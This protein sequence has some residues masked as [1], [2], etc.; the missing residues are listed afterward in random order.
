MQQHLSNISGEVQKLLVLLTACV[1]SSHATSSAVSELQREAALLQSTSQEA[2][3]HLEYMSDTLK[4]MADDTTTA[5]DVDVA[6]RQLNSTM[7]EVGDQAAGKVQR[8]CSDLHVTLSKEVAAV[9]FA[10]DQLQ[11]TVEEL[12]RELRRLESG[13]EKLGEQ[14]ATEAQ[15]S[16]EAI[17]DGHA[18]ILAV[19]SAA[20]NCACALIL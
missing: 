13:L 1:A 6:V 20:M 16:R 15:I 3:T 9:G 17:H 12:A 18:S 11:L 8:V 4:L 14:V 19:R 10:V 5:A 2:H 7:L